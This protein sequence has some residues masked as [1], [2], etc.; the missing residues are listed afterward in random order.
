MQSPTV[1]YQ[2]SKED[3]KT[4]LQEAINEGR[5]QQPPPEPAQPQEKLYTDAEL[6]QY[7][8]V[9][10]IKLWQD[11]KAGKLPFTRVGN[12]I[13]YTE[14]HIQEYLQNHVNKPT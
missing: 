3:L 12:M 5:Q 2:V 11:R 9:S 10:R 6:Q 14:S 13:R 8:K 1:I 7:A 4:L